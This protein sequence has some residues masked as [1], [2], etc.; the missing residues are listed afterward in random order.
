MLQYIFFWRGRFN[1][2]VRFS[3]LR[4]RFSH[5]ISGQVVK[6]L[7]PFIAASAVT[8]YLVNQMQDFGVRCMYQLSTSVRSRCSPHPSGDLCQGPKEPICSSD[9]EGGRVTSL[10]YPPT[11]PQ[12]DSRRPSTHHLNVQEILHRV[13]SPDSLLYS[14]QAKSESRYC[15]VI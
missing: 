7:A 5:F 13:E 15:L 8:F 14:V 10:A 2:P 4:S 1:T 6:P 3:S 11:V 12:V 9:R